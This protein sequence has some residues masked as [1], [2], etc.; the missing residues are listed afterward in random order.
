MNTM[1]STTKPRV[2][3]P[4]ICM[5]CGSSQ[6]LIE[7]RSDVVEFKGLTL[8]AEGLVD[9]V[10]QKCQ[11]RWVTDGQE[12]DN[13]AILRAA[14][15]IK[16]DAVRSREGL[17]TAEQIEHILARL[18]L[19]KSEAATLF[20]G[21]ANAFY[22]Y[23]GG[24]VLQSFPMDR[25]LRLT[26]AFGQQ[27]VAYLRLGQSAPLYLDVG[28]DFFVGT[29]TMSVLVAANPS[30]IQNPKPTYPINRLS[31]SGATSQVLN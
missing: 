2:R 7:H 4:N 17:L 15:S 31:G 5:R 23:I 25:L 16:R 28:K 30:T 6:V 1:T 12:I 29:G 9:T 24:D 13:L 19:S 3:K 27:A 10:C 22:K 18:G 14:Y 21:G 26:L 8:E 20:G 11:H